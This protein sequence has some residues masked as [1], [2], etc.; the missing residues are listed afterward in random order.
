MLMTAAAHGKS[1]MVTA[2]A[3]LAFLLP[4]CS[5]DG[6]SGGDSGGSVQDSGTE[7]GEDAAVGPWECLEGNVARRKSDGHTTRCGLLRCT[8]ED[9]CGNTALGCQSEEDCVSSTLEAGWEV[10]LEVICDITCSPL[11]EFPDS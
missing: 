2:L 8:V 6:D 5:G 4:N 3:I 7:S 1:I 11:Y 10:D 9:G